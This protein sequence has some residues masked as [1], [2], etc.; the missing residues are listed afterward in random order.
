MSEKPYK[1]VPEEI[2]PLPRGTRFSIYDMII[3][4][5]LKSKEISVRVE[6]PDKSVTAIASG[7]RSRIRKRK[8]KKSLENL[9]RYWM[10]LKGA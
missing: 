1:L 3:N 9:E 4:E 7:L 10:R 8:L 6:Y 2:L 5:F